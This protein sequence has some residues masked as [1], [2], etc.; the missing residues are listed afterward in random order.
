[1]ATIKTTFLS[2]SQI[3]ALQHLAEGAP[4]RFAMPA[5]DGKAPKFYFPIEDLPTIHLYLRKAGGRKIQLDWYDLS[6]DLIPFENGPLGIVE[7]DWSAEP[8]GIQIKRAE[9]EF[10]P[11]KTSIIVNQTIPW[12]EAE[13]VLAAS[14][15][16]PERDTEASLTEMMN[17]HQ[18][19]G[20]IL[21]THFLITNPSYLVADG[22]WEGNPQTKS[23]VRSFEAGKVAVAA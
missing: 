21:L 11:G 20:F 13:E 16:R 23:L 17:E 14:N 19:C 12:M 8:Q 4:E 10:Q 18:I 22:E 9:V 7:L 15:Y 3:T 2:V 6:D 1:M 5:N